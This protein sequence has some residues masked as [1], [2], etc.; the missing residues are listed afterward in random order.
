MKNVTKT[1]LVTL[2][3]DQIGLYVRQVRIGHW[4]LMAVSSRMCRN[5][6]T[7]SLDKA[8]VVLI[9]NDSFYPACACVLLKLTKVD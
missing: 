1:E 7:L 9:W 8:E 4:C 3:S 2:I 6:L 5:F